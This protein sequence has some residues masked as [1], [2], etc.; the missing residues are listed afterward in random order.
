VAFRFR[1]EDI[2]QRWK[3]LAGAGSVGI[4]LDR[5]EF[6]LVEM[7]KGFAGIEIMNVDRFPLSE[8]GWETLEPEFRRFISDRGLQDYPTGL[9]V[10]HEFGF[11]RNI[12]LP[13]A[14]SENLAQVLTYELDRFLPFTAE[15]VFFDYQVTRKTEAEIHLNLMALQRQPLESMLNVLRSVGL[16][17][18]S[19]E[20]TPSAAVN[21][22]ARLGGKLTESWLLIHLKTKIL[23]LFTVD[24]GVLGQPQI[25]HDDGLQK[26]WAVLL[27]KIN[28]L[29]ASDAT[30]KT[31]CFF[32][33]RAPDGLIASL[34]RQA[35]ISPLQFSQLAV[36]GMALDPD[37]TGAVTPAVGAALRG[38][39]KVLVRCN[40]LPPEDRASVKLTGLF[41]TRVLLVSL[42]LLFFLWAGSAFI[43][44]KIA[45]NRLEKEI[46]QI[47]PEVKQ[48]NQQMAEIKQMTGHLQELW[49][50]PG[51][52]QKKLFILKKLTEIIPEHTWLFNLRLGSKTLE[53]NGVSRSA[54][55][56]IP[57]LEKSGIFTKTEFSSPIVTDAQGNEQFTIRTDIKELD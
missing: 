52:N 33:N 11:I 50:T 35:A 17:P 25:I 19:L 27:E 23:E 34:Q 3:K 2:P 18:I 47:S 22:F 45:L 51:Q 38:L 15:N 30:P 56:L 6:T 28:E 21:A 43:H 54:A 10:N 9:A 32:G 13:V 12:S 48:I 53:M 7:Q 4:Y 20:L 31:I 41:L 8:T 40:L 24:S 44:K 14:A 46:A 37:A 26:V 49:G 39:G 42:V 55:D 29:M 36:K 5:A 16:K 57:L 1:L